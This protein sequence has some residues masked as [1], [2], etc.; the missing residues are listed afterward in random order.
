MNDNKD[1]RKQFENKMEELIQGKLAP[2][3]ASMWAHDMYLADENR[4]TIDN[5]QSLT[6][7]FDGLSMS[8]LPQDAK[9]TLMYDIDSYIKWYEEY[10]KEYE[11]EFEE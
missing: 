5:S 11:E 2:D 4:K 3:E 9:D 6:S 7:L 8:N 1:L 10:K